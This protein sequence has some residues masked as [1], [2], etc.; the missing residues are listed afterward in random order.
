MDTEKIIAKIKKILE[1][2]RNNPSKEEA[3][4]AALKAQRLM[5]E[6]HLSESNTDGVKDIK[7]IMEKIIV[8]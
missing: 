3:K 1:L 6:Y 7:R 4:A 2:S 8:K 5:A